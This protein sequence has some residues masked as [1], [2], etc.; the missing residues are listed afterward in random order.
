MVNQCIKNWNPLV[1]YIKE[2]SAL[3]PVLLEDNEE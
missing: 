2:W 3:I 1:I